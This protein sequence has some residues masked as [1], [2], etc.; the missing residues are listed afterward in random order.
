[1]LLVGTVCFVWGDECVSTRV[2]MFLFYNNTAPQASFLQ[3]AQ[4]LIDM[5]L[6]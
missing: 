4:S 3:W 6:F 2:K 5:D 1:M